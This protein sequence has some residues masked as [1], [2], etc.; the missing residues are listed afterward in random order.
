MKK[1]FVN[2]KFS[3]EQKKKLESVSNEYKFVYEKSDDIYDSEVIVG[4]YPANELKHFKNLELLLLTAVGYDAFIKKDV[5]ND[6]T[7]LCNAVDIHSREVAEHTLALILQLV[8]NLHLYKNNQAKHLWNDEGQVKSIAGLRV[9]IIGFGD[10]G[11]CLAKMLKGLGM[12]VIGVKRKMIEKPVYIDEL[13]TNKDMDE[14]ISN[15][16]VV[17]TILPGTAENVHLFTMD[18]FKKMKPDT[19]LVN[20]GR[21]NLYDSEVLYEVL[22]KKIIKAAAADV[23]E[24]EPLPAESK[25]YDLENFVVTPHIAGFFHLA[26]AKEEFLDLICENLRR[27]INNEELKYVVAEREQ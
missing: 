22:N 4:N 20:C 10:I 8:K 5:L 13:H 7:I 18:T 14:V 24:V 27:Y 11:N 6:N 2:V 25:L 21:G 17:V 9:A 3:D 1:V 12:Y 19:V 15:V 16:D 26:S 23:F